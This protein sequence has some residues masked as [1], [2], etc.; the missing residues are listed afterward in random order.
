VLAL[1]AWVPLR[2]H[3]QAFAA[4][5]VKAAF[6]H[7]FASYVEWPPEAIGNGAFVIGVVGA[8]GVAR[9]LDQLLPGVT[10]QGRRAEVRRV[11]RPAE[12]DG[13]HI[14]Y[15]G[16]DMLGRARDLRD[17]ALQR[18]VLLVTDGDVGFR[19]GGVVNF[20]E[21]ESKVRFEVSLAA[22]NRARLKI[23]SALLSVAARVQEEEPQAWTPWFDWFTTRR[24]KSGCLLMTAATWRAP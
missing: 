5:A 3:A 23:D 19:N 21:S 2:A 20:V 14:V 7:R 4:D 6:L 11:T 10:V 17:A 24:C 16:P 22:A 9:N 15:F 1:A 13:V 12:L 8:E 18:P